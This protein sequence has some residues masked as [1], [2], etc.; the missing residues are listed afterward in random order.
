[1]YVDGRDYFAAVAEAMFYARRCIY[2]ADWWLTPD[3]QLIRDKLD[4]PLRLRETE[5]LNS[6]RLDNLLLQK[7]NTGVEIYIMVWSNVESAVPIKSDYTERYLQSLHKSIKV[8]RH[9]Y[10]C[11]SH[12]QKAV[13]VDNKLAFIGGLDICLHRF[14]FA[15]H[16][17]TDP[18]SHWFV[19]KDYFSLAH[20]DSAADITKATED[21]EGLNRLKHTRMPCL[22]LPSSSPPPLSPS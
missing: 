12:H 1:M 5:S 4:I 22:F 17:I 20:L 19:G 7:A 6:F 18:S 16:P 15:D 13:V 21:F 8:I 2:I 3:Y 10:F 9:G 11:W 14:D